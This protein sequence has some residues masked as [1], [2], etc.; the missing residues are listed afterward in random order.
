MKKVIFLDID[1]VLNSDGWNAAHP[2]DIAAGTLIDQEKVELLA[3]LVKRTQTSLILHSGWR[4]WFDGQL[5]PLRREAEKLVSLLAGAGLSIAGTTPDLTTAEI[6]K[7]RKFSLV[8]ADEIL[9]WLDA[10][11][12]VSSW[13]VLDDLVLQHELVGAHQVKTDPAVGLTAEDVSKAEAMLLQTKKETG[14]A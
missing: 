2:A 12:D 1:G 14:K 9:A 5:H 8:K 10:H 11:P 7:T 6:R 3:L 4:M 13:V